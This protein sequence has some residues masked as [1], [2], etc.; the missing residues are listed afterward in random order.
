MI[1]LSISLLIPVLAGYS[2]YLFLFKDPPFNRLAS[3]AISFGI[4]IGM[5]THWMV[6]LSLLKVN[7]NRG[8]I[9]LPL[10]VLAFI[11]ILYVNLKKRKDVKGL[12]KKLY[13]QK[14][15]RLPIKISINSSLQILIGIA[16]V[17]Y[18]FSQIYF[19]FWR[20]L[21]IPICSWDTLYVIAS[22]AKCFFYEGSIESLKNFNLSS[23]P[24]LTPLSLTWV[25]LNLGIWEEQLVK[26]IFPVTFLSY[27]VIHYA[28][29]CCST[30]KWWALLGVGLLMSA[31]FPLY[32]AT[33]AYRDLLLMY[34]NMSAI[35]FLVMSHEM[36]NDRFIILAGL[37]SGFAT[38]TKLEAAGYLIVNSLALLFLLSN[39]KKYC[40]KDKIVKFLKF[41]IPS[42]GIYLF[43]ILYKLFHHIAPDQ[44]RFLFDFNWGHLIRIKI[45]FQQFLGNLFLSGNWNILWF[46]LIISLIARRE[47]IVKTFQTKF[48]TLL[49]FL[50]FGLYFMIALFTS[51]FGG[52][53]ALEGLSRLI[54]H[55]FPLCP[56]LIVYLNYPKN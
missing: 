27:L 47:K 1:N 42:V 38:F 24:L 16:I 11:L 50:Y 45:I 40:W 17:V 35:I 21:N 4:G 5:I 39:V 48:F 22:K 36:K 34:Y 28:F 56:L 6:I 20:A 26:I 51:N 49:L 14:N 54:L 46:L 53:T 29:L 41:I 52:I 8:N 44:G 7:L 13:R 9:G 30:T 18:V 31:N 10:I 33:I 37:F 32:H 43:F 12:A 15:E 23:Y 19:V 2:I 55:F 25:A 3:L